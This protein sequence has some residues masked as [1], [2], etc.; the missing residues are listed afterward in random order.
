[1]WIR[2]STTQVRGNVVE[3]GI[4]GFEAVFRGEE[5][6]D[7]RHI[8]IHHIDIVSHNNSPLMRLEVRSQD[9]R[10]EIASSLPIHLHHVWVRL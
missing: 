8:H 9:E 1:M 2:T 3:G 5:E 4:A 10:K 7:R 6:G